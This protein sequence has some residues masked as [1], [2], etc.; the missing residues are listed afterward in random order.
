MLNGK[1]YSFKRKNW[2]ISITFFSQSNQIPNDRWLTL[3]LCLL[4]QTVAI[5]LVYISAV[6]YQSMYAL[7]VKKPVRL[8]YLLHLYFEAKH[9]TMIA[10]F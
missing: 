5:H 8:A 2:R 4:I 10:F 7:C 6:L 1:E 9:E 3:Y